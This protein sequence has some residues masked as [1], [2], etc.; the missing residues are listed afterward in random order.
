MFSFKLLFTDST[1]GAATEL[2]FFG[3][4]KGN[5][6]LNEI[7]KEKT[8]SRRSKK[9]ERTAA[10]WSV[11]VTEVVDGNDN[12]EANFEAKQ[13]QRS[14]AEAKMEDDQDS[15]FE[16]DGYKG[17]SDCEGSVGRGGGG[18][19]A[20][21]TAFLPP[22]HRLWRWADPGHKLSAKSR[23]VYHS[24]IARDLTGTGEEAETVSVGDCAVF[25]S[26]GRPDRPYIG[27]IHAMWQ[28]AVA[29]NMRY[30][31]HTA[32]TCFP[33]LNKPDNAPNISLLLC[34]NKYL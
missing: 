27:R 23:R 28:T 6:Y 21:I 10:A 33:N 17:D 16:S 4:R 22:Q 30:T 19:R 13:Q 25:L 20:G 14:Q 3:G 7:R 18:A 34:W 8:R 32:G 5:D 9:K 1:L 24:S 29:G 26:T 2:E 15:A 31:L 11:V 12:Y